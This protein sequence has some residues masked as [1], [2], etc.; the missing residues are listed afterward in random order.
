MTND[1]INRAV[2]E[3]LGLEL[4]EDGSVWERGQRVVKDYCNDPKDAW[5]IIIENKISINWY[6][7]RVWGAFSNDMESEGQDPNNPL[8]AAMLCFLAM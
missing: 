4:F 7:D 5:T 6:F 8:R 3:K 2:S 1:E